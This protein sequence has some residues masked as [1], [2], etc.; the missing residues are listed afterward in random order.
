VRKHHKLSTGVRT[1]PLLALVVLLLTA[2]GCTGNQRL[3]AQP[4]P[5]GVVDPP[6][7]SEYLNDLLMKAASLQKMDPNADYVLGPED[8]LEIE[9][10]QAEDFK[11]T[12]RVSGQG[13]ISLPLI[14]QVKAKGLTTAQLEKD[15]HQRLTKYIQDPQV[16]IYIKEYKSQRVGV[17]GAVAHP[18]LYNVTGQKYLIEMLFMAGMTKDAGNV[19][20]VFR[21]AQGEK[22][23]P[24]QTET[25]A[26]DLL[27]LMEKGNRMLNIPVFGGDIINVPKAGTVFV[28]GAVAR[29]GAFAMT[30][31]ATLIQAITMAGGLRFEALRSEIQILRMT[32]N[33][34][35]QV[36]VADYEAAK[37]DEKY[38]LKDGDIVLVPRDGFKTF[39]KAFFL[40]FRGGVTFGT[41]AAQ[42]LSVGQPWTVMEPQ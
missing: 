11:R 38:M 29:P 13:F 3:V 33:G 32:G 4:G 25:I 7:R 28:D 2:L 16:T 37:T 10:Y 19:C 31:G 39:A 26:I 18:Q 35:R 27:E 36:I 8:V 41:N 15:L 17:M 14:G 34:E 23:G 40:I 30:S 24:A 5:N 12:V 42:T 9:A 22:D 20:Y 6:K 21:P 1:F